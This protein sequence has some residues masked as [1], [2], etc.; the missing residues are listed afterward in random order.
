MTIMP[1]WLTKR[2]M[3]TPD[4][5]AVVL[6]DDTRYT[7][8]ELDQHAGQYAYQLK[9]QGI[10]QDDHVAVLSKNSYE[11]FVMIHA[12]QKIGAVMFL[13]NTRLSVNEFLFQLKDG[14]VTHLLFQEGFRSVV[15]ELTV[16][17]DL[18][19]VSFEQFSFEGK[20]DEGIAE[21]DLDHVTTVLYTSGTTGLP[22]GV[23]LTYGNHW[24]NANGSVLNLGLNADDRWLLCV[25]LFHVSGL[26]ILFRSVIYGIPAH[27][28]ERFDVENVHEDIMNRGVTTMSAVSVMLEELVERLGNESYPET[29]RCMLLGGGPASKSLL[30]SSKEKSIP[31]FQTYGMTETASQFCTLD[32]ENALRKLG[33]AG[34]PLFPGQLKIMNDA[35]ECRIGEV[36]EILMKGPSVTKGYWNRPDA[37]KETIHDC[38]LKTGD[39]GYLDEEGFLYVVDRRKDLIISGGENVYPAEIESVLKSHPSVKDAGVVGKKHER[40]GQVPVA[41]VV[42]REEETFSSEALKDHCEKNLAKY[43]VPKE[44]HEIDELPRNA[45]RKLMRNRLSEK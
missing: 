14:E 17:V 29:F 19:S 23:Q 30:E 27:L 36:G 6:S 40:W 31:V 41:F 24:W 10:K 4:R 5:E 26:S 18:H 20:V 28:H 34:K 32:E 15:D 21:F 39:L 13:L 3:M 2:A 44:F 43:K 45:S 35:E 22:K 8:K 7:F 12:L 16:E 11:M 1:Q 33:S 37:N 25:P 42:I 9:Q 38:W